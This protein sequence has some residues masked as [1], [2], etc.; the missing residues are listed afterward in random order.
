MTEIYIGK[1]N[2][3]FILILFNVFVILPLQI[4]LCLKAKNLVVKNSITIISAI[5]TIIFL[6]LTR[7]ATGFDGLFY[8]VFAM[9]AGIILVTSIVI[10]IGFYLYK[11]KNG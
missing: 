4:F 8:I 9:Y 7:F 5:I 11:K 2:L 10:Q 6:I 3:F 1:T